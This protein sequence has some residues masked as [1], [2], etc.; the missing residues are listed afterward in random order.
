VRRE[1]GGK[2]EKERGKIEEL[3]IVEIHDGHYFE[4]NTAFRI[5]A[6]ELLNTTALHCL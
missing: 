2:I 3:K 6:V 4:N 1:F 5:L